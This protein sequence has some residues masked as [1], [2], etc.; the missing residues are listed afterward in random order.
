MAPKYMQIRDKI[1]AAIR[2]GKYKVGEKLPTRVEMLEE[3]QV[4]RT[5]LER[6]LEQLRDNGLIT[7]STKAGT[8]IKDTRVKTKVGLVSPYL[9]APVSANLAAA[10]QESFLEVFYSLI[11]NDNLYELKLHTDIEVLE[12]FKVLQNYNTVVWFQPKSREM[13]FL[14]KVTQKLLVI[15]RYSDK[16][17]F[18]STNHREAMRESTEKILGLNPDCSQIFFIDVDIENFTF[19]ERK[20]GFL[21]ACEK[22]GRFYRM[23]ST[24]RDF[25][26]QF[27]TLQDMKIEKDKKV[28]IVSST[29]LIQGAVVRYTA[30]NKKT[31]NQDLIFTVF[32][33]NNSL[34]TCGIAIP[35][36]TQDYKEMGKEAYSA[37][38][39]IDSGRI[40]I[41]TQHK[42][43]NF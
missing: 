11:S 26:S 1:Q 22:S 27:K 3:F 17:S 24:G 21:D 20:K 29:S 33:N 10:R 14:D 9:G 15:N 6:A 25:D 36:V 28:I 19:A 35:T 7:G 37:L 31:I 30:E 38:Q 23:L 32:D 42:L 39:K 40:E 18:V 12:N 13:P 43:E 16:Y 4:T 8:I 41:F 34:Q 2:T 5:T